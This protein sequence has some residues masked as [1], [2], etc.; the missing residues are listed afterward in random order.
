V[1][2][3]NG[4]TVKRLDAFSFLPTTKEKLLKNRKKLKIK[5]AEKYQKNFF[6][7]QKHTIKKIN[8]LSFFFYLSEV[9]P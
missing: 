2:A 3:L 8:Y 9:C 6:F 7:F 4:H 1:Y 5:M